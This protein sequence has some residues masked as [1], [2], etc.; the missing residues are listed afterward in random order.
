MSPVG[1]GPG[2]PVS[3]CTPW[4]PRG[5]SGP[6]APA[7]PRSRDRC[8]ALKSL[9]GSEPRFTFGEVTAFLFSC[10]PPTELRGNRNA[11]YELPPSA[12]NRAIKAMNVAGD[13]LRKRTGSSTVLDRGR[14]RTPKQDSGDNSPSPV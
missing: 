2:G 14:I 7:G 4:S 11:A 13:G 6:R 9:R 1:K 10:L 5:P 8:E 12:T 3:P